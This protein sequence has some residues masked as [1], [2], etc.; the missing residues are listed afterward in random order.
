VWVPDAAWSQ[1]AKLVGTGVVEQ[2]AQQGWSVALSGDGNIAIVGGD[3]DND[4]V[5]AAWVFTHSGGVWRQLGPKL[6]GTDAVGESH[7]GFSVSLSGDGNTAIVGGLGDNGREFGGLNAAAAGLGLSS[8]GAL[9][10]AVLAFC[11]G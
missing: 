6:V 5:G 10:N 1:Q 2:V 3:E 8:V 9:Q 11:G 7:Q 4:G